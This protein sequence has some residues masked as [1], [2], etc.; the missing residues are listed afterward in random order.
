MCS[1]GIIRYV[2]SRVR[3]TDNESQHIR[4]IRR[5]GAARAMLF[6]STPNLRGT[7]RSYLSLQKSNRTIAKKARTN[8]FYEN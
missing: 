7:L 4:V 5:Q 8:Y 6:G 2:L 3:L 1:M